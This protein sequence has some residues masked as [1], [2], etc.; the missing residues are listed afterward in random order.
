VDSVPCTIH[1]YCNIDTV[2][3][4]NAANAAFITIVFIL[5]LSYVV[6]FHGSQQLAT[7]LAIS[8]SPDVLDVSWALGPHIIWL[9]QFLSSVADHS[10]AAFLHFLK[11]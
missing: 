3:A 1:C 6:D 11:H 9:R 4:A 8:P 5:L 7:S 10:L 2:D